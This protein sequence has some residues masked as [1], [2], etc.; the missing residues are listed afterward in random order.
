MSLLI[1]KQKKEIQLESYKVTILS[2][3]YIFTLF[4]HLAMVSSLNEEEKT[5]K[6]EIQLSQPKAD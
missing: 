3:F 5:E 1:L 2:L 4:C 6:L